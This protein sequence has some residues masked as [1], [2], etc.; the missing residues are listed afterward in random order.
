MGLFY[1]AS[2]QLASRRRVVGKLILLTATL[3]LRDSVAAEPSGTGNIFE[4]SDLQLPAT[5]I[6][7]LVLSCATNVQ[8]VLCSDAVFVRRAY[9]DVIGTLPTAKEA[10]DFIED[11]DIA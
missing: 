10:R 7:R 6:D 1:R 9:L 5:E 11:T 3:M 8:T 2:W 4:T